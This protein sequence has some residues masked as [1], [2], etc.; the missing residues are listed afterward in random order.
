MN[1]DDSIYRDAKPPLPGKAEVFDFGTRYADYFSHPYQ[2]VGINDPDYA[3]APT[4]WIMREKPRPFRRRGRH[5]DEEYTFTFRM[6]ELN[7]TGMFF[8]LLRRGKIE[9][10]V[11]PDLCYEVRRRGR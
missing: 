9:M 1:T 10:E 8:D 2:F 11:T 5:P 6:V 7:G 3:Q 4:L